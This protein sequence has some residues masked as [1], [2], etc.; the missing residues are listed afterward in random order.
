MSDIALLAHLAPVLGDAP[1]GPTARRALDLAGT[2]AVLD[3]IARARA[4]A[5]AHVWKLIEDT[6][7]GFPWLAVAGKTLTGWVVTGMDAT[8]VTASSDKEGAAP[9]C[10]KKGYGFHPLGAWLA[11]TR[12]CPA[13][14]LRPGNAGPDTFTDHRDVLFTCGWMI[15]AADEDAIRQA[16]AG[17]WKPGTGQDGSIEDDK[18]VAE[19]TGLMSRAGNWPGGCG[20][21]ACS[22]SANLVA[23]RC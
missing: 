16:P 5:R 14:L 13:V 4:R 20:G 15:T 23:R 10:K 18:D 11:N 7:A 8:L 6:P 17:A 22:R 21:S 9:T 12:E 1:S 19:I 2:P 3:R